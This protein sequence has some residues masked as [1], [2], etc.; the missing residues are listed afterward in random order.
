MSK[1]SEWKLYLFGSKTKPHSLWLKAGAKGTGRMDLKEKNLTRAVVRGVDLTK[2]RFVK[3]DFSDSFI[4]STDFVKT[5]ITKCI[6]NNALIG[7]TDFDRSVIEKCNF[8]DTYFNTAHFIETKIQGGDW[9]R[10]DLDKSTWTG[11]VVKNVCFQRVNLWRSLLQE[12]HFINCDFR[13]GNLMSVKADNAVFKNCD[14]RGAYL[15]SFR[16]KN[17]KF[18]NCGFYGCVGNPKL[19]GDCILIEPDL[20]EAFDGT[21]IVETEQLLEQWKSHNGQSQPEVAISLADAPQWLSHISREHRANH[22]DWVDAGLKGSGK[23]D[24]EGKNLSQAFAYRAYLRA[25]RFINCDFTA[26]DLRRSQVQLAEFIG[27]TFNDALLMHLEGRQELYLDVET[28]KVIFKDCM[29]KSAHFNRSELWKAE[30]IGGNWDGSFFNNCV[31]T[32]AEFENVSFENTDWRGAELNTVKFINCNFRGALFD[33]AIIK[34]AK[35]INCD[36]RGTDFGFPT[37]TRVFM[38]RCGFY[39]A[40]G[41]F[42]DIQP[43]DND[44]MRIADADLSPNFDGS[45][46]IESLERMQNLSDLFKQH[47]ANQPI[48][49][50]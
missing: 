37:G 9:T 49:A 22:V 33:E 48:S 3:C 2:A 4:T 7:S 20:S 45:L 50:K 27:C 10:S 21:G 15:R 39:G 26:S 40:S 43:L 47:G 38:E 44:E 19:E 28:T 29:A 41:M 32:L 31:W 1:T 30:F 18:I 34:A 42:F 46:A 23:L 8:I 12:S 25:A 11:A 5:E 17:T 13:N 24:L 14:F 36:F 6:W 35:F 16:F